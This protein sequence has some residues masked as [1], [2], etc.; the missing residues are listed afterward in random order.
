MRSTKNIIYSNS[1]LY[2]KSSITNL[3]NLS[4][5]YVYIN[6]SGVVGELDIGVASS[7]LQGLG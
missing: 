2:C 5:K 1:Y 7:M 4:Y 6:A 3:L